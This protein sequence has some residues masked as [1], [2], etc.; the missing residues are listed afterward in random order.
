MQTEMTRLP[1]LSAIS[2]I[3]I[4]IALALRIYCTVF[5]R[6]ER[7]SSFGDGSTETMVGTRVDQGSHAG[8]VWHHAGEVRK[9]FQGLK[10]R[11]F[12]C[13]QLKLRTTGLFRLL[14]GM[15]RL[16]R[17]LYVHLWDN[18]VRPRQLRIEIIE[19]PTQSG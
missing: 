14:M 10:F 2:G 13:G 15:S 3:V 19:F 7:A 18:V 9:L 16:C 6:W 11:H 4:P 17:Q 5:R 1:Q 12:I 8:I